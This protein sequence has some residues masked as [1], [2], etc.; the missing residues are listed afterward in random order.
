MSRH[1]V[2][3]PPALEQ[4]LTIV[5]ALLLASLSCALSFVG[6]I[7]FAPWALG[8]LVV[9]IR[10]AHVT[11]VG[12]APRTMSTGVALLAVIGTPA[13]AVVIAMA[14]AGAIGHILSA[15]VIGPVVAGF[16]LVPLFLR[17]PLVLALDRVG[18]RE[19][20]LLEA[21]WRSITHAI[22]AP[23]DTIR[24]TVAL[25]GALTLLV[26]SARA[27]ASAV[28]ELVAVIALLGLVPVVLAGILFVLSAATPAEPPRLRAWMLWVL[29][30]LVVPPSLGVMQAGGFATS[31]PRAATV[32]MDGRGLQLERGMMSDRGP[33]GSFVDHRF[34]VEGRP[35]G[36]RLVRSDGHESWIE[37]RYD[38]S[39]AWM[40]REPC[41]DWHVR[42]HAD[43][44][45]IRMRGTDWEMQVLLD[46]AGVRLD[47][48]A[49]DRAFERVGVVGAI[50]FLAA[51][52][53]LAL[54]VLTIVRVRRAARRLAA[55]DRRHHLRG[56]LQL[57]DGGAIEGD[58]IV[59]DHNRIVLDEAARV[60]RLPTKQGILAIEA[61][62]VA[63]LS[64]GRVLPVLV[65]LDT[66][67]SVDA[68]RVA[69]ALLPVDAAIVVGDPDAIE[70]D[71]L[72]AA[73]RGL[74]RV[75]LVAML[76]G[77]AS[78]LALAAS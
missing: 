62:L 71:A 27:L 15:H 39:G 1:P 30:L 43:C 34:A 75:V 25:V 55:R 37:T 49:V 73:S 78:G 12:S 28:G 11:I 69:D 77:A 61:A 56:R 60:L 65:A 17:L 23:L 67:P 18:G 44:Q 4:R 40:S 8:R 57:G 13:L 66:L 54:V 64:E 58:A 36:V 19:V 26:G 33:R 3:P 47:D 45:V 14:R 46:A 59:G 48:G 50:A 22:A 2:E 29:A 9:A 21:A 51:P 24:F 20:S 32:V 74:G 68:H 70:S 76:L 10:A 7:F 42:L 41:R 63:T 16:A 5:G 72:V 6:G 52:L 35:G 38:A 53:V 31:E